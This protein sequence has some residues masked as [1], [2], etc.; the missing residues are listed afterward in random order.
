MKCRHLDGFAWIQGYAHFQRKIKIL[1]SVQCIHMHSRT[2]KIVYLEAQVFLF[3]FWFYYAWK[4]IN[5]I[6][7]T[8]LPSLGHRGVSILCLFPKIKHES[9]NFFNKSIYTF[10]HELDAVGGFDIQYPSNFFYNLY[11]L[12]RIILCYTFMQSHDESNFSTHK[13]LQANG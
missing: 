4:I 12:I 6:A 1:R 8:F 2:S 10:I 9:I 11:N 7:C 3:P 13:V 5:H